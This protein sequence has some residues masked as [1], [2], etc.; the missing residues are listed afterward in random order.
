M[1]KNTNLLYWIPCICCQ[2]FWWVHTDQT[3]WL[4][5]YPSSLSLS[6]RLSQPHVGLNGVYF[7]LARSNTPHTSLSP[8]LSL[9]QFALSLPLSLAFLP[10]PFFCFCF[11]LSISL[12]LFLPFYVLVLDLSIC[13]QMLSINGHYVLTEGLQLMRLVLGNAQA[14]PQRVW[15]ALAAPRASREKDGLESQLMLRHTVLDLTSQDKVHNSCTIHPKLPAY[16]HC[17]VWRQRVVSC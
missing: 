17:S 10:L 6:S 3:P 8:S 1:C 13:P 9:F 12:S 7:G 11:S 2:L 15:T 14:A 5:H 4:S 16:S